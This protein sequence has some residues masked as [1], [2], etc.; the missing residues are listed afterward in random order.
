[1]QIS[2][3]PRTAVPRAPFDRM[4]S[5]ISQLAPELAARAAEIEA[6]RRMPPD[7]VDR[8]RAIGLFRAF[9]PRSHGGFELDLPQGLQLVTALGKIEGSVGWNVMVAINSPLFTPLLPRE[10][11]DRVYSTTPDVIFSGSAQPGGKA[12]L[13]D[14]KWHVT[15]RWPFVSGC[16]SADWIL[17]F[18]IVMQDGKPVPGAVAGMPAVKVCMLP[19]GEWRIEDT[20]HVAGLRGTGSHHVALDDVVVAEDN[21]LDVTNT[22]CIPGPL[23]QS[24]EQMVSLTHSAVEVGIA[25][26]AVE[27]IIALA[28]TGRQQQ[29]AATPM[30][31]SEIFQYELGRIQADLRAAKALHTAQVASHWRHAQ[32]GTLKDE[33]L[34]V[35]GG[36]TAAWINGT[37]TRV[38]DGCYALGGSGALY[39]SSPLQRRMRDMHAAALHVAVHPRNYVSAGALLLG[40]P[41]AATAKVEA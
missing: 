28:N 41:G 22:P 20:W 18:C 32:N 29:R 39:D 24:F 21:M 16:Q 12:E 25:E 37:C 26:G 8:L 15:G 30:Q 6:A 38:V 23:Y 10:I 36:Q 35:Q 2:I 14:G 9:V 7:L 40:N 5:D 13:I 33:A 17:G 19:A 4:L 27:D 11:Y 3:K 34:L 1:L 31:Q